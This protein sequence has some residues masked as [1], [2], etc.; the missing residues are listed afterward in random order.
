MMPLLT[1][2]TLRPLMKLYYRYAGLVTRVAPTPRVQ[3]MKLEILPSVCRPVGN[4]DELADYV[5]AGKN[6]LELGSGSGHLTIFLAQ[7]SEHVT[8]TDINPIAVENTRKNLDERRL[9]NVTTLVSDAF[10]A[11]AGR[12]D[13]IAANPPWMTLHFD[14]P[15]LAWA[16]SSSFVPTIVRE[17]AR[18]L[19]DNGVLVFSYPS[20]HKHELIEVAEHHGLRF[21]SANPRRRRQSVGS[22][23]LE[24]AY[25]NIGFDTSIFVFR[26]PAAAPT[27]I[28]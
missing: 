9:T 26:K 17:A 14:D 2:S 27:A 23:L 18:L 11:V 24:L 22:R 28:D 1:D 15:R 7:K 25:L 12:F 6:V 20:E 3:G 8:A 16:T 19:V 5:P 4:W 13:A 10:Q 21:V